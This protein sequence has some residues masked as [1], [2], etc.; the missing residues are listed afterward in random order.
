MKKVISKKKAPVLK[1]K[2]TKN[3]VTPSTM[4][5]YNLLLGGATM[6]LGIIVFIGIFIFFFDN[7]L[8]IFL[9]KDNTYQ[10]HVQ[11]YLPA[12]TYEKPIVPVVTIDEK[13]VSAVLPVNSSWQAEELMTLPEGVND[14]YNLNFL[15]SPDG[16]QFAYVSEFGDQAAV[17]LNGTMGPLYNDII[18]MTFSPDSRYFAY[19]VKTD[20]GEAVVINNEMK[21]VYDWIFPP[22]FFTPDSNNFVYKARQ[23]D[24]DF[25]V[26]NDQSGAV[27]DQI[28][29]PF[30]S[31]DKKT[32][33]YYAAKDDV[34]YKNF[35][36][37]KK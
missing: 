27:Y 17:Y 12:V 35:L 18:F 20:D 1:N 7:L 33:I 19:G 31:D 2:T 30:V 36:E 21:Q 37:L 13:P 22:Y 10:I 5:H 26:F 16:S 9:I 11:G 6:F 15:S 34:I 14:M 3:I 23:D 29:N 25:L 32:L 28:Y 24:N 4:F 8:N